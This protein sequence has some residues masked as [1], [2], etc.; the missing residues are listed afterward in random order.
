[1]KTTEARLSWTDAHDSASYVIALQQ[2]CSGHVHVLQASIRLGNHQSDGSA[3][4]GI[5]RNTGDRC[6]GLGYLPEL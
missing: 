2:K 1:M 3:G 5:A 6:H 4:I